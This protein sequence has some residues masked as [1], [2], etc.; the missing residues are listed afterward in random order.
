MGFLKCLFDGH[1]FGP[2]MFNCDI[3]TLYSFLHK[4][5]CRLEC[6]SCGLQQQR[7]DEWIEGG[8]V[9]I[10]KSSVR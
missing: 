1:D 4:E 9:K 6:L 3:S 5:Q 7:V 2:W 10:G 8:P